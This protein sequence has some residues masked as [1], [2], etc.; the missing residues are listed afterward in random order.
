MAMSYNATARRMLGAT[1]AVLLLA[2]PPVGSVAWAATPPPTVSA[3]GI[4][5]HSANVELPSSDRM[6]PGGPDAETINNNCLACHSA[7]MVLNQP[8]MTQANWQAEVEKMQS[9]YKAP[10]ALEDVPTIVDYLTR[11]KGKK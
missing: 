6:F 8:A 7:G 4:T 1:G 10:L 5:L 9:A 3:S 2:L 11:T